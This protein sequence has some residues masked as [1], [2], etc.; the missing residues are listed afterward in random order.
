MH[1]RTNRR[2]N[3]FTALDNL[4]RPTMRSRSWGNECIVICLYDCMKHHML[5]LVLI[6]FALLNCWLSLIVDSWKCQTGQRAD[7]PTE[8]LEVCGNASAKHWLTR[9]L[10]PSKV[11]IPLLRGRRR[12]KTVETAGCAA[13]TGRTQGMSSS[14]CLSY[15]YHV[16]KSQVAPSCRKFSRWKKWEVH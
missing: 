8:P 2:S 1:R 3:C 13:F 7:R 4:K 16:N 11:R 9:S 15:S 6:S 10:L 14:S 5:C 12:R